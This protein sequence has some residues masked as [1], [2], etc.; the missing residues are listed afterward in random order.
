MKK[1]IVNSGK[2]FV[3]KVRNGSSRIKGRIEKTKKTFKDQFHEARQKPMS[4][5]KLALLGFSTIV[6]MFGITMLA[7]VLPAVARDV[8]APKLTDIAPAVRQ[9]ISEGLGGFAVAIWNG[10]VI[11]GSFML[12]AF[13]GVIVVVGVLDVKTD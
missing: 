2:K 7:S 13:C 9:K 5:R 3:S 12:G 10:A 11:S 8:P 4:K 6:G 1:F